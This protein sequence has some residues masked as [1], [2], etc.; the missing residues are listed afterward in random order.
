[1]QVTKK[2]TW[3]YEEEYKFEVCVSVE[4]CIDTPQADNYWII[5]VKILPDHE[6]FNGFFTE[7]KYAFVEKVLNRNA[8]DFGRELDLCK[9]GDWRCYW[10][11][12]DFRMPADDYLYK[13]SD[14]EEAP[15]VF[16][17]V[18]KLLNFLE[19]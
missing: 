8:S 17:D 3:V 13:V 1:M 19:G 4:S 16:C 10:V 12:F 14:G 15:S 7:K 11:K 5:I 2:T 6:M 9:W 18:K